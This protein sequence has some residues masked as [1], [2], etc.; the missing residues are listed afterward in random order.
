MVFIGAAAHSE[1]ME[2]APYKVERSDPLTRGHYIPEWR[3]YRELTQE[4]VAELTGMTV[5]QISKIENGHRDYR[6]STLEL[7][8]DALR[9]RPKNLLEPPPTIRDEVAETLAK[10]SGLERTRQDEVVRVLN[11]LIG[12]AA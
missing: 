5:T 2:R 10:V 6:Q 4:K 1:W 3:D 7:F 11:A 9:C 8:A 12:E